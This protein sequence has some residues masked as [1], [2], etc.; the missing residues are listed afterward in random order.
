[1]TP[2]ATLLILVGVVFVVFALAVWAVEQSE[3]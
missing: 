2:A 1:M 3:P